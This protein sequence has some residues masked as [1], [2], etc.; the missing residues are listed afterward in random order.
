M[1]KFYALPV[2]GVPDNASVIGLYEKI[3]SAVLSIENLS[4][5]AL[6]SFLLLTGARIGEVIPNAKYKSAVLFEHLTP[7]KSGILRLPITEKKKGWKMGESRYAILYDIDLY[8]TIIEYIAKERLRWKGRSLKRT[9]F[10]PRKFKEF[11]YE[12]IAPHTPFNKLSRIDKSRLAFYTKYAWCFLPRKMLERV[13]EGKN[14]AP[15]FFR[16]YSKHTPQKHMFISYVV[17]P[18]TYDSFYKYISKITVHGTLIDIQK[19]LLEVGERG[20]YTHIGREYLVN[21]WLRAYERNEWEIAKVLN[22]TKI[23][24]INFYIRRDAEIVHKIAEDIGLKFFS[25]DDK[26]F[27]NEVYKSSQEAHKIAREKAE[28]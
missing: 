9:W 14:I 16:R 25:K 4:Y 18:F 8:N 17:F 1:K 28:V 12:V 2:E 20:L 10:N 27:L 21:V 7:T 6:L 15:S 23:E 3:K 26:E 22:W 19:G 24:N 13:K 11:I 5:R